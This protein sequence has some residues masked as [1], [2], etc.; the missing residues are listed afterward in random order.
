MK[1]F[2]TVLIL[3]ALALALLTAGAAA[4]SSAPPTVATFS[5]GDYGSFAEGMAADSH[6]N[7]WVSLT[8]WGLYDDSVDPPDMT[9]NTGQIW[10]IAPSGHATLKAAID[11]TPYGMLLGV[12][13]RDD[14][15]YVAQSDQGAGTFSPG[16]YRLDAGGKLTQVVKLPDGAW[17]NGIAFHGRYLFMTDSGMGA[18][19][20]ARVD[21]GKASPA[22]RWLE[23]ALLAPGDPTADP[24]MTGIGA[25]GIAFR[26]DR[27]FVSVADYGRV[28]RIPVQEDGSPGDPVVV[29]E[30]K[31]LKT[32]DGI[33]FDAFGGLWIATDSGTTGASPSGALYRLTPCAGLWTI[34]DDPGWLNYPTT[35]VFG[36]TRDTRCTLFVENGAFGSWGDGSSPDI[37]ALRVA[38]PGLPLW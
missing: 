4:A 5:P 3:A 21:A 32:A 28:V 35:P 18:V 2:V 23:D 25:N 8:V 36:I 19:W 11:L 31:E 37:R 27:L 16:V 20:R 38:I 24:T 15:V 34:A 12:A 14:R 17:P 9:S 33:A 6:G 30:R 10:K 22:K 1:R 26:G 29:C 13:V 7:L